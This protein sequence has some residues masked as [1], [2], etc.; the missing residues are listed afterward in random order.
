MEKYIVCFFAVSSYRYLGDG[1]RPNDRSKILHDIYLSTR[2][3]RT[4]CQ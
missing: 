3:A 4:F 1:G 2:P